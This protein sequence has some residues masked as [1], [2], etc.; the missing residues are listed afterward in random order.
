MPRRPATLFARTAITIAAVMIVFEVFAFLLTAYYVMIPVAK[1]SADDLAAFIVTAVETWE[2]LPPAARPALEYDLEARQGLVMHAD[3]PPL[4]RA[5]VYLPYVYFLRN[6]LI[7]R[8]QADI[9]L[10]LSRDKDGGTWYWFDIPRPQEVL[11]LGF[12]AARIDIHIPSAL[13]SILISS[14]L[15][16]GITTIVLVRHLTRPLARLARAAEQLGAGDMPGPLPETGPGELA[17]L[18]RTFNDMAAQIQLLLSNRTVL[19]AGIAHDL[20][21][22]IARIRLAVE[23]LDDGAGNA[24]TALIDQITADLEDMNR[25]IGE[26]LAFSRDLQIG[27]AEEIAVDEVLAK[28]VADMDPTGKL[29]GFEPT[30]AP[31]RCH[32]S[33]LALRRIVQNLLCNALRYGE[34]KPIRVSCNPTSGGTL[35]R[36]I[37]QGPGIPAEELE[38]VFQPFYRLEKSRSSRTGGSGLGLAIARQL[39]D[40]YHWALDLHSKP[41][42]GTEARLRISAATPAAI[43]TP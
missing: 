38:L 13:V 7:R 5:S 37:D 30:G 14:A 2:A 20:R 1:R 25:L 6:S 16:T 35:I 11:R 36:V 21:T 9:R 8:L 43:S 24:D 15:L 42:Q 33:S 3:M 34:G 10:S 41:G 4:A 40:R 17:T 29:I 31:C 18:A 27:D 26:S 23:M 22:P 19:L 39:A 28:L 12:P 32:A